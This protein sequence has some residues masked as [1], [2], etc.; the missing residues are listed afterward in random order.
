MHYT[1]DNQCV[2]M[3]HI[4]THTHWILKRNNIMLRNKTG[5]SVRTINEKLLCVHTLGLRP[6]D[7]LR[8]RI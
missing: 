6:L 8:I 2:H 1:Y 3:Q 5:H 7:C 4:N